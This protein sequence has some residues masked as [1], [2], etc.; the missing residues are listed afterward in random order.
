MDTFKML[1]TEFSNVQNFN[2]S[3]ILF[4]LLKFLFIL[5]LFL[6]SIKKYYR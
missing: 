1:N 5:M 4:N 3:I 2:I 6:K